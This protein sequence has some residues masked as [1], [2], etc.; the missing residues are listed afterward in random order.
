MSTGVYEKTA[1]DLIRDALRTATITGIS[2]PVQPS[3][4]A[5][6]VTALNDVLSSLQTKQIHVWSNTEAVLPLNPNQQQYQIGLSGA[7]CFT[8]YVYTT[9]TAD[10]A[11][12]TTIAMDTAGVNVGD[13]IGIELSTGSRQWSTVASITTGA[14]LEI[15]DA[16]T[17]TVNSSASVYA[18]TNKID[19]PVRILSA[20]YSDG[21]T[22]DEIPTRQISRDEYY[23]QPS[24]T[25]TGSVNSWYYMR[26]LSIGKL[27]L[28]PI[29]DNCTRVLRFTFIKP[30]YIPEDASENIQIPA[31]WFLPLK[32]LVAEHL[33]LI[34]SIDPNKQAMIM[35]Q[36]ARYLEDAIGIDS[37]F[38]SFQM[39]P[40]KY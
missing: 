9:A 15:V 34:Y 36:A 38:S 13:F 7:H 8:D 37:E 25:S 14:E 5:Q 3:D 1:G 35:Q 28:W 6:G 19:Q 23:N 22:F 30:Q 11:S 12:G 40:G 31:E 2:M 27:N 39:Y 20:R 16:L 32:Y 17:A 21:A 18:Y 29:A 24:K 4:Y 26:D 10:I 33:G